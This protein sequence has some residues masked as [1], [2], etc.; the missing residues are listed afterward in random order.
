MKLEDYE[1]NFAD[2]REK[3]LEIM[4]GENDAAILIKWMV[5]NEIN[6]YGVFHETGYAHQTNTL[7][8]LI[9]LYYTLHHALYDDGEITFVKTN[10]YP[11]ILFYWKNE[12]NFQEHY[13]RFVQSGCEKLYQITGYLGTVQEYI[14][15]YERYDAKWNAR[16]AK[17]EN[18]RKK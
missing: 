3:Y 16:I 8:G 4:K 18:M 9:G 1:K 14:A 17:L 13:D 5:E 12:Y 15:E 2:A 6:F 10:Y 11:K 7:E